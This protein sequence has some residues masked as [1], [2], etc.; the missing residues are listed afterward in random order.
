MV[1]KRYWL[2]IKSKHQP[3]F[4]KKPRRSLILILNIN[5]DL[6]ASGNLLIWPE[7]ITELWWGKVNHECFQKAE[8]RCPIQGPD[9]ED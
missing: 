4:D 2:E 8:E 3:Y 6:S 9:P 1:A 7:V 5:V